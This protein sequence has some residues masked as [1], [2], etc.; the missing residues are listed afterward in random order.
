MVRC[1]Y[2]EKCLCF[3]HFFLEIHRCDA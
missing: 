2:C 3:N 1:A